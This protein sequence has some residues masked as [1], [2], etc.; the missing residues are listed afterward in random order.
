MAVIVKDKKGALTGI[1]AVV[2]KVNKTFGGEY[3]KKQVKGVYQEYNRSPTGIFPLD[4]ATGGGLLKGKINTFYG[5]ESSGKSLAGYC[6][7]N[8]AQLDDP[9]KKQV[10]LDIELAY[11]QE[12]AENFIGDIDKVVVITAPTAEAYID[13]I[14]AAVSS[15]DVNFIMIDSIAMLTPE[16]ELESS[17]EKASVGGNSALIGKMMRKITSRLTQLATEAHFPTI[18]IINQVRFKI[19]VMHGDPETQPG[20][21]AMFHMSSFI[22]RFYGKDEVDKGVN[23]DLPAYKKISCI[24]KKK[25]GKTLSRTC[26]FYMPVI[27]GCPNPIGVVDSWPTMLNRMKYFGMIAQ[28]PVKSKGWLF[29]GEDGFKNQEAIRKIVFETPESLVTHQQLVIEQAKKEQSDG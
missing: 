28:N 12:W 10:I 1:D 17:A 23:P 16:N 15:E 20:G 26:E 3:A 7:I 9:T 8:Q 6:A 18:L 19:G 5:Q 13:I 2:A 27:S 4:Y 21:K 11:E 25:K 24:V 29:F 14:D 22:V